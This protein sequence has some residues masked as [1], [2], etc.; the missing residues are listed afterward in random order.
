MQGEKLIFIEI[1]DAYGG[2]PEELLP[3]GWLG[4]L[5]CGAGYE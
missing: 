2:Y 3:S 1:E 5:L 4:R